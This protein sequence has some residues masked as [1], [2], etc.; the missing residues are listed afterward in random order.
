ML[1]L[2]WVQQTTQ[3]ILIHMAYVNPSPP[4]AAYMRHW[5]GSAF[6][7]VRACCLFGVKPLPDQCWFIVNW[8]PE[9]KFQLI[10]KRDSIIFIQENAFE[11]VVYQNCDHFV[12]GNWVKSDNGQHDFISG[13]IWVSKC[14]DAICRV[15]SIRNDDRESTICI[16]K[17][18]TGPTNK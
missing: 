4:N 13:V 11:N 6:I 8:T 17:I 10:S 14:R 15:V 2:E 16:K 7:Q 1:F 3:T 12:Q 9:N 5:T 18:S